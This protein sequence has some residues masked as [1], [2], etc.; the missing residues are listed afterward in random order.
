VDNDLEILRGGSVSVLFTIYT[1]MWE[2]NRKSLIEKEGIDPDIIHRDERASQRFFSAASKISTFALIVLL[3]L[4]LIGLDDVPGF[5][6]FFDLPD[7]VAAIAGLFLGLLGLSIC[8]IAQKTMGSSW[9]VGIDTNSQT[10]LVIDGIFSY[11]RNPTYAGLFIVLLAALFIFPTM[12]FLTWVISMFLL[13][14]FQ[15]RLEDEHLLKEHGESYV[16]CCMKVKRYIP[17]IY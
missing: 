17:W 3:V 11:C 14:E 7:S 8:R 2:W 13:I 5:Y 16:E 9:R 12:S 10:D 1:A 15:T 4:H 6:Y